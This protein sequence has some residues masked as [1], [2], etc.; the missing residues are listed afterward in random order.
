MAAEIGAIVKGKVTG[1]TKFGAFVEMDGGGT[2]LCHISEIADGYVKDV[3]DFLVNNQEV[4]VKVI[5]DKEGKISLSIRQA[6]PKQ[7][8]TGDHGRPKQQE[9][10]PF[11]KKPGSSQGQGSAP[12][13]DFRSSRPS[14]SRPSSSRPGDRR[15]SKPVGFEDM[16]SSF[17]KESDSQL[18]S[19]KKQKGS[20]KG[21]GFQ[22]K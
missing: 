17:M 10:K 4:T 20:R 1:I 21:N 7:E 8:N 14:S 2:G 18:K 9:R 15:D 5:G 16:L 6:Q 12:R 13:K 11:N 3:N 22:K 19:I